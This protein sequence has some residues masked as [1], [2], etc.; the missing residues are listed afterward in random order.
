[1]KFENGVLSI[2]IPN[3]FDGQIH[4][5]EWFHNGQW[6]RIKD[7]IYPLQ[8]TEVLDDTLDSGGF[9]FTNELSPYPDEWQ[10]DA[11]G[12][13]VTDK[14]GNKVENPNSIKFLKQLT[15][16]RIIWDSNDDFKSSDRSSAFDKDLQAQLSGKIP[17][18]NPMYRYRI[19]DEVNIHGEGRLFKFTVKTVEATKLLELVQCDT[20]TFTNYLTHNYN[21]ENFIKIRPEFDALNAGK[22]A[23]KNSDLIKSPKK[24]GTNF[25][26]P[27][28]A[29]VFSLN[30]PI[31]KGSWDRYWV[32][33]MI[34]SGTNTK[35][36]A[37]TNTNDGWIDEGNREVTFDEMG[38]YVL[39][40]CL[41][42]TASWTIGNESYL[43]TAKFRIEAYNPVL[44]RTPLTLT[45]VIERILRAG[46]TRREGIEQQ[47]FELDNSTKNRFKNYNA[48]EFCITRATMWEA[49]K[50]VA[51]HVHCIPRLN[52]DDKTNT[53]RILTFD[54]L[55]KMEECKLKAI[56][57]N[58][59]IAWDLRKS[60]DSYCGEI[61]SY[62]DNLVNTVD[63]SDG[64]I[65]EPYSKGWISAR[66]K[67]GEVIVKD[68]TVVFTTQRPQM[69]ISK[70]EIR[71]NY[72]SAYDITPYI[73]E[74]AEYKTLSD[75]D[76]SYPHST[77]Y[78]LKYEQGGC[79]I[80]ELA[81]CAKGDAV[82]ESMGNIFKK[83]AI[84]NIAEAVGLDIPSSKFKDIQYRITY[85]P[86]VSTRVVQKKSYLGDCNSY[87]RNYNVAGNMVESEYLGEHLKGAVA[88]I[89]ND[90]EYRTYM[91]ERG[92]DIPKPGTILDGKYIMKVT[93]QMNAVKFVKVTIA[94]SN[95]YNQKNEYVA[96]DSS[97][98][99]YDVSEKQVQMRHINYGE[100]I[101]IGDELEDSYVSPM[102]GMTAILQF[103]KV[104]NKS[105]IS[106]KVS[107]AWFREVL[108]TGA[109]LALNNAIL[110]PCITYA[111]GNSLVF[112]FACKDN[113]GAGL[114]IS[115]NLN[116]NMA[117]QTEV[118]YSNSYGEIEYMELNLGATLNHHLNGFERLSNNLPLWNLS[119]VPAGL[120]NTNG[121]PLI[122]E[123]DSREQLNITY[124]LHCLTNRRSIIL[125]SVLCKNN[126]LI[127]DN[128]ERKISCY[129]LFKPIN[130]FDAL[131]DVSN[132]FKIMDG[133]EVDETVYHLYNRR[134]KLPAI[135][136]SGDKAAKAIVWVDESDVSN[137]PKLIIGENIE[138]TVG[139]SSKPIWFTFVAN[140]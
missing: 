26:I 60:L 80:T 112:N 30:P 135:I 129:L 110:L 50:T 72:G 88:R 59:P 14:N 54:K 134:F 97:I 136:N 51:G 15:P 7:T 49:L 101:I 103:A 107:W 68:D 128:P 98:R 39:E 139:K 77:A 56:H 73:F 69:R 137:N 82:V 8:D 24:T 9:C 114:R 32:N 36:F 86:I 76:G 23:L 124:Q 83:E 90:I 79:E 127:V 46:E 131:V 120:F 111:E 78:A 126:P 96:I 40:Y 31:G 57:N 109:P 113:F 138:I 27:Y 34:P 117:V 41:M 123:K 1:M 62:I 115:K 66:A 20:M 18:K 42:W 108:N 12:R 119:S 125:G 13:L 10:T 116:E 47:R 43:T 94:L 102:A 44:S 63:N 121:N 48:P 22:V 4:S 85:S 89:G 53:F 75:F 65:T 25:T 74:A 61:D 140:Q 99:Y 95:D 21:N 87:S 55:G 130:K 105:A 106:A 58:K 37:S 132:G 84:R 19:V 5:V 45:K 70:I 16:I 93:A 133:F 11:N 91:F 29:D 71:Y 92:K 2:T 3:Q 38:E 118:P 17:V 104:F 100:N 64:T 6:R 28:P 81:H 67:Q 122:I 35:I 52:W 33:L